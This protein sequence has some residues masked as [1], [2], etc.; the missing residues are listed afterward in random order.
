MENDIIRAIEQI[1]ELFEVKFTEFE[2]RM[3]LRGDNTDLRLSA[4]EGKTVELATE[5]KLIKDSSSKQNEENCKEK[6]STWNTI[7][8]SFI[9]WIIPIVGGAVLVYLGCR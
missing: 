2:K 6:L 1:K 7:K 9:K 4:L 8:E 3:L 5:I